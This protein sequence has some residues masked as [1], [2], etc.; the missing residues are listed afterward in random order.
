HA[1]GRLGSRPDSFCSG[2]ATGFGG[3]AS[4]SLFPQSPMTPTEKELEVL[5]QIYRRNDVRQRDLARVIGMSLGM[6]NAILKRLSQK[7]LL[8]VRKVNNRNIVYAVSPVGVDAIARK[9]YR[10]LKRTI[11]HVINYKEAIEEVIGGAAESGYTEV[12]LIGRS[13]LDFIVEHLCNKYE[14]SYRRV[15]RRDELPVEP[16]VFRLFSENENGQETPASDS[17]GFSFD[18]G[19]ASLGRI[20]ITG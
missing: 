2:T 20:L 15:R 6:T 19:Y 14:L 16:A 11:R 3:R 13:D 9:S 12:A 7:G 17:A 10:Y 5:E 1:G 8:T 4:S 18:K